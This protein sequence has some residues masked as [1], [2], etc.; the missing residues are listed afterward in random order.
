MDKVVIRSSAAMVFLYSL[1]GVVGYLT[2]ADRINETILSEETNGNILECDYGGPLLG[3]QLAR[4]CV[5]IA[6]IGA[7]L[8]CIL[9]AKTT[10]FDLLNIDAQHVTPRMNYIVSF[11]VVLISYL[12]SVAIPNI[13][14]VIAVTG[15]TV[16]PFVGFI[17]PIL[18]YL[19]LDPL[20][21][22]HYKKIFAIV[23]LVLI[24]IASV[25]GMYVY[26][27]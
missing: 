8:I 3:I 23:M 1:I 11:M 4:A 21:I 18:F 17:Y 2:F 15:A 10:Y 19:K 27:F 26:V 6:I 24:I 9:P 5:I 13:K 20:P 22:T 7:S 25:M 14:D 16:N 12:L